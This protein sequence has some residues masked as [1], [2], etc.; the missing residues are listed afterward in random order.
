MFK[1]YPNGSLGRNLSEDQAAY[2]L[3]DKGLVYEIKEN[4]H[5]ELNGFYS[6][7]AQ[8]WIRGAQSGRE[9]RNFL[10]T[11]TKIEE[12]INVAEAIHHIGITED[13]F[14]VKLTLIADLVVNEEKDLE[15][16][17]DPWA[18]YGFAGLGGLAAS[19]YLDEMADEYSCDKTDFREVSRK[20]ISSD[21]MH[22]ILEDYE[23]TYYVFVELPSNQM[24]EHFVAN[25]LSYVIDDNFGLYFVMTDKNGDHEVPD[26]DMSFLLKEHYG[27]DLTTL[28]DEPSENNFSLLG[29]NTWDDVANYLDGKGLSRRRRA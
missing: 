2:V 26:H 27:I 1:F 28:V 17:V 3:T 4:G 25:P 21:E 20:V 14:K 22:V 16:E 24:T 13:D 19:D 6:P 7:T 29:Q 15:P 12:A 9:V 10:G 8:G 18:K 23:N 11:M 5:G